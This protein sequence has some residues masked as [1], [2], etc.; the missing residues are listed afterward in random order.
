MIRK[1]PTP[2]SRLLFGKLILINQCLLPQLKRV[3]MPAMGLA[4]PSD[5]LELAPQFIRQPGGLGEERAHLLEQV[6]PFGTP[7][8]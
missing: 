2:G 3:R 6:H 8:C 1:L 7:G 5:P 4:S